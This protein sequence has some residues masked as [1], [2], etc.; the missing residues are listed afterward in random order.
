MHKLRGLPGAGGFAAA[1][2]WAA[3]LFAA[4][5]AGIVFYYTAFPA[6]GMLYWDVFDTLY[7]ANATYE[8]GKLIDPNFHYLAILP[9]GGN[10]IML[11]LIALF[12]L[13]L[14][15][16]TLGMLIF[17][18]IFMVSIWGLLACFEVSGS[19]RYVT[20]GALLLLLS[21][22]NGLR[23]NMW[24]HI[25]YYS[26]AM[27]FCAWLLILT[28]QLEKRM[29]N[30]LEG[31]NRVWV[32][33]L[34][35]LLFLLGLGVGA[36]GA[37]L[38]VLCMIPMAAALVLRCILNSETPLFGKANRNTWF[39]AGTFL[40]GGA[41]G[42][43]AVTAFCGGMQIEYA[44]TYMGF[45]GTQSWGEAILT[46]P[47]DWAT[48]FGVQVYHGESM[49][50][51]RSLANLLRIAGAAV[52]FMVPVIAALKYRTITDSKLKLLVCCHICISFCTLAA[53]IF[54]TAT[55]PRRLEVML[56]SAILV[57][58]LYLP[59]LWRSIHW[60]RGAGIAVGTLALSIMLAAGHMLSLPPNYRADSNERF[61]YLRDVLVN[62]GLTRAYGDFE[63]NP[64][65]VLTEGQIELSPVFFDEEYG[66]VKRPVQVF[67]DAYDELEGIEHYALVLPRDEYE[68]LR[69]TPGWALMQGYLVEDI[70]IYDYMVL[71]YDQN[72]IPANARSVVFEYDI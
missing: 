56:F 36:D 34:S 47:S 23:D 71:I 46:I 10:L 40:A 29:A 7:W 14:R 51:L 2:K 39:I 60:R 31:R 43:L 68:E 38:A 25:I 16:H 70:F 9:F 44:E 72:P 69:N 33:A 63:L 1:K 22:S 54:S 13:S 37:P 45:R 32:V 52:L 50:S 15:T 18:L 6:R 17:A 26:L 55:M 66:I 21:A 67:S 4:L 3:R 5:C 27:L 58:L 30:R 42:L 20:F 64:I 28:V 35:I 12:G 62:R 8:S 61:Y 11:P 48:L 41:A 49:T 24:Q 53:H 65:T 57:T 19:R 59:G